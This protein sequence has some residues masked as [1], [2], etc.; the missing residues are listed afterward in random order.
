[1]TGAATLLKGQLTAWSEAEKL[2]VDKGT[3]VWDKAMESPRPQGGRGQA[4]QVEHSTT[5]LGITERIKELGT[6]VGGGPLCLF[7][8]ILE[9]AR[10]GGIFCSASKS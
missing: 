5:P 9:R 4:Q 1:M 10:G 2:T 6:Q 8:L 3:A 7:Y